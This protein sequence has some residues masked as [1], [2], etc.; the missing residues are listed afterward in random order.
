MLEVTDDALLTF[1][2]H[3]MF[4][5]T[6]QRQMSQY[7]KKVNVNQHQ[8]LELLYRNLSNFPQTEVKHYGSL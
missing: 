7:N 2:L 1:S 5:F 8:I 4:H 3:Q 6:A